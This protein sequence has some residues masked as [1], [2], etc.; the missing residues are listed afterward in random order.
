MVLIKAKYFSEKSMKKDTFLIGLFTN[1][2]TS[3][4]F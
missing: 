3:K 1:K 2:Y 4:Y